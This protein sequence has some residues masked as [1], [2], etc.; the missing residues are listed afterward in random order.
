[1]K[2][3][4]LSLMMVMTASIASAQTI[5]E[6]FYIY[7]N[8]GGF[9]AFFRDEVDSI[10]YSNYDTDSIWYDDV[11]TQ[12]V[13]TPD[14]TYCIP[15]AVIDSV[16]FVTPETVYKPGVKVIDEL[17][18]YVV[19]SDSLSFVLALSTPKNLM[20]KVGDKVVTTLQSDGFPDGFF[21]GVTSMSTSSDGIHIECERVSIT[22]IYEV[23]YGTTQSMTYTGGSVPKRIKGLDGKNKITIRPGR[24]PLDLRETITEEYSITEDLALDFTPDLAFI[25]E[26]IWNIS[27][28]VIVKPQI[29]LYASAICVGDYFLEER[30]G[31]SGTLKWN[32]DFN[33]PVLSQDHIPVY[34]PY[35]FAYD[36]VGAFLRAEFTAAFKWKWNQHYRQ[37]CVFEYSSKGEELLKKPISKPRLVDKSHSDE[38]L[39]RGSVSAGGF[40]ELG[41]MLVDRRIAKIDIRGEYG[42]EAAAQAVLYK[43][44]YEEASRST[45]LYEQMRDCGFTVNRFWNVSA[46]GSVGPLGCSWTPLRDRKELWRMSY[47]P[48]FSNVTASRKGNKVTGKMK[49]SGNILNPVGVGFALVD[50]EN[51]QTFSDFST[52]SGEASEYQDELSNVS[53]KKTYTMYPTV[54][55]WEYTMLAKPSCEVPKQEIP[56][57]IT[58]FEV[59]KSEHKDNGFYHNG[60]Y[61]DYAYYAATTVELI[62][63]EGVA[64]WGYVYED[65]NGQLAHISL[66]AYGSPYT[67]TNYAYY[68]NSAHDYVCLYEYVRYEGDPEYY[69]GEKKTYNLDYEG[70]PTCPDDNHPHMIDLGLPSGTKWACCNVGASSPE[71]Y[72]GY[73]AWGETEE[74]SEYCIRN[75]KYVVLDDNNGIWYDKGHYYLY[76]SIG[77]DISGTQYDVAHVKWGGDWHMPTLAQI[78]ELLNN[79]TS[80]WTSENGVAGIKFMGSNGGSIFLPAAGVRWDSGHNH[81]GN[82]G[83]YWSSTLHEYYEGGAYDANYLF[84]G[85]DYG[86]N[87]FYDYRYYGRSVRPVR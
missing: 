82:Y 15:L 49:A 50:E 1:M 79:T 72:G 44:D 40:I 71:G 66:K 69:Y 48:E 30:L 83:L 32:H 24:F 63:S 64:D 5:G 70:N 57:E 21:G 42:W 52:Y 20:P 19:S 47:V 16:G 22:D 53:P 60:I 31:L 27:A 9:N 85:S 43:H 45:A 61:F 26:P 34:P 73:Y 35:L 28:F 51:K 75:Y 4:F 33:I 3:I 46:E 12:V 7:R 62:D 8:D 80:E 14:S 41:F 78:Q 18:E 76:Q 67:D 65:P 29:G 86:V 6:A 81:V 56:V 68:R 11:V 58:Y 77:S 36:H 74:K 55:A 13:Y 25:F 59:T 54:K 87:W 84:F 37:V 2:K 39:L 38:G 17:A 10:T 23:F